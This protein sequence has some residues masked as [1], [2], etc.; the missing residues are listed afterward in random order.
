M[1]TRPWSNVD[2]ILG[3]GIALCGLS[4]VL[5]NSVA[6]AVQ[7]REF[8][9]WWV[10]LACVVPSAQ[11][12]VALG[13]SQLPSAILRAIWFAQPLAIFVT[14]LLVYRGWTTAE[15]APPSPRPWLLDSVAVAAM[16]LVV[17][18][19][20]VI[21]TA[22]VLAAAVPLSAVI[23]LGELPSSVLSWGFAHCLNVFF[24]MIVLVLRQRMD[25]LSQA[26]SVAEELRAEEARTRAEANEF[27][28]FSRVVHDEVLATFA[29]ALQFD[30]EPP[31]LVRHSAGA[32]LEALRCPGGGTETGSVELT[33]DDAAQL[34]SDLIGTAAPEVKTVPKILPGR[35]QSSAV[36]AV[37][38]AAAEAARNAARHAGGGTAL[39]MVGSESIRVSIIDFGAGF[40]SSRIDPR[41]FGIRE[42]IFRRM[43]ELPGGGVTLNSGTFGT[44]VVMEWNRPGV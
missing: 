3:L 4:V 30:G 24:V 29:A 39:V 9:T 35:V 41:R 15:S 8:A 10:V 23:F 21:A 7:T 22:L 18:L 27:S 20:Y 42:S 11:F 6:F 25:S 31:L 33:T 5:L 14:L 12:V 36:G 32:A 19:P 37:G 16:V 38:L 2:R 40:D 34:I 1:V 44:T 17:R 26:N 43:E 13:W 28:H